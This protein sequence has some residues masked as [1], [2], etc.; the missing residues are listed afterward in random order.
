[1]AEKIVEEEQE[2]VNQELADA[3]DW[4]GS[5]TERS[6]GSYEQ[7]KP[8]ENDDADESKEEDA[9]EEAAT[10]EGEDKE[11]ATKED[12]ESTE[13]DESEEV[14]ESEEGG[15]ATFTIDGKKYT[16]E[17]IAS[18]PK[19]LSKMA[20]HYNQV[21]HFQK[22]LDEERANLSKRDEAIAQLE[23]EKQAIEKEWIKRKMAEENEQKARTQE[24]EAPKP[25][26]DNKQLQHQ[27]KPYFDKLKEE[28]RLTEDE[29]DE[30]SGLLAEYMYDYANMQKLVESVAVITSKALG[31]ID[32]L[33]SFVNP[34]VKQY[35]QLEAARE[36]ERVQKEAAAIEG[37]E[38]LADSD[39]WEKLMR[40]IS[41]KVAASPQDNNGRPMFDPI[42][43]PETMAQQWDAMQGPVLRKALA[44]QKKKA[45]AQMKS[46]AKRAS[47]SATSG[48]KT[49]KK[50][51]QQKGAPTESDE[52]LDWG[53][54]RYAG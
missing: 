26:P 23:Q 37:Y 15:V 35:G 47:G 19:L 42:F 54:G 25:R 50:K 10:E 16:S 51:P 41:E 49:P 27:L 14:V 24:A 52:A 11:V 48:G 36:H 28:G 9:V 32:E 46:D 30:H 18:D 43:D 17:E 5:G 12:E 20:T 39:N 53:D 3:L 13:S 34:A 1:M 40:Y 4:D 7:D 29:I 8:W 38:E 31:R 21:G 6:R 45:E 33:E 2:Q 22:L 44:E